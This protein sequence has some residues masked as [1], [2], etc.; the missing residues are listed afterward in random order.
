MAQPNLVVIKITNK[1]GCIKI[2][3]CQENL[4]FREYRR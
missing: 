3:K 4:Y 1:K 2:W